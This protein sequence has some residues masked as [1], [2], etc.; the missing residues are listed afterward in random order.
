MGPMGLR[1]DAAA[2]AGGL[3]PVK[4]S[5]T[6]LCTCPA[7]GVTAPPISGSQ[8]RALS[9]WAAGGDEGRGMAALEGREGLVMGSTSGT[10]RAEA[11]SSPN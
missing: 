11:R 8:G 3:V 9:G 1:P 4:G 10:G 6:A 5:V 2:P 7:A